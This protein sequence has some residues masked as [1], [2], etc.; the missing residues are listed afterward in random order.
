MT[1]LLSNQSISLNLLMILWISLAN[2]LFLI[3]SWR[4]KDPISAK[5]IIENC[6]TFNNMWEKCSWLKYISRRT[7][8]VAFLSQ[9]LF[10]EAE[11][12]PLIGDYGGQLAHS[13]ETAF[14]SRIRIASTLGSSCLSSSASFFMDG[15]DMPHTEFI[16]QDMK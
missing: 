7:F 4:R 3:F 15:G 14:S 10:P 13:K 9:D 6:S 5:L 8:Q 11:I 2:I 16:R 12:S 1:T